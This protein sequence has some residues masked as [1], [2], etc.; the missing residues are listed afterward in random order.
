MFDFGDIRLTCCVGGS[1]IPFM[2]SHR[3]LC[4]D[5][6]GSRRGVGVRLAIPSV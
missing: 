2:L 3:R 1:A 6:F 5:Q 4:G